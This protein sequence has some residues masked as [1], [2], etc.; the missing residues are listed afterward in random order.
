MNKKKLYVTITVIIISAL[1]IWFV[2]LDFSRFSSLNYCYDIYPSALLK[3]INVILAAFI[4]WGV[5]KDGLNL[6]DNR[7]MKAAFIFIILGEAAFALGGLLVGVCLFA[8]SQSLLIIRNCTGIVKSLQYASQQHK[9]RLMVS[10]L[11]I[12]FV[13]A[14]MPMLFGSLIKIN[15][16]TLIIFFYG[17]V[18]SASLWAG[19]TCNMLG[20][21]PETNSKMVAIGMICFYCCDI[22]VGLDA[23]LEVGLPWL[24]ANSFIWIFYIPALVLLALSCYRYS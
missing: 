24:L 18:L 4:A 8:V 17:I 7:K 23:V 14:A 6:I 22:L 20:L 2:I 19:L 16:L 9:K 21:L 11:T 1:C 5:G 3:R 12:F 13:L 10:G 15:S